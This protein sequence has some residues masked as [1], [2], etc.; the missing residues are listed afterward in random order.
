M[1]RLALGAIMVLAALS[2]PGAQT[3]GAAD[4]F[5]VWDYAGVDSG[6]P[7]VWG[8]FP[9]ALAFGVRGQARAGDIADSLGSV[10]APA[11]LAGSLDMVC[12]MPGFLYR[13]AADGTTTSHELTGAFG[14]GQSL[15]MGL[16]FRWNSG[17]GSGWG[18]QDVGL[19]V[20]PARFAS[21]SIAMPDAFDAAHDGYDGFDLGLSLRPLSAVPGRAAMLT[22]SAVAHYDTGTF[23]FSGVGSR[24][25]LND[26]LSV[27]GTYDF[28]STAFGLGVSVALSGMESSVGFLAPYAASLAD[29]TLSLAQSTRLGRAMRPASRIFGS[30]VL[31][32]DKPGTFASSPPLFSF[33]SGLAEMPLWAGQAIAA[34]ESA[35]ADPSIKAIVMIEPPLFDTE[36]RAQEFGRALDRFRKSGKAIYVYA[37]AMDRLS[38]IYTA[39]G[40][41]LVAMDPNGMLGVIDVSAF[42]LYFRELF[43]KL[44]IDV[45][46]LR[47]HDAKTAYNSFSESGMTDA[48]RATKTRIVG[49][50]AA[51]GY[52]A[53]DA[54]HRAS[55]TGDAA[56]ALAAGPYLDPTRAVAA[57]LV[58]S[59]LYRDEFDD[60]VDALTGRAPRI[61]IRS[62]ARE[63]NLAWPDPF[64]RRVAIVYLSG[65]IIEGTGVAG[66]SIGESAA[67][68][69]TSLVDDA[70]VSGVI[71]R[72][73]SGGGSAMTSDHI[74]RQV[75]RLKDAHKPVVVSMAGYAASGGYYISAN[76]DRILAEA[77]TMTGSIGVTG[78]DINATR[79]L[80]SLGVGA[81]GVSA[82]A[83]GDYG[84]PF[85][86]RRERDAAIERSAIE[87]T[88]GRFVDVVAAGR[89]MDRAAVDAL[90][91][92][93]VW[94][95]SEALANGLVDALGGLDDAKAAIADM[96]GSG[97]VV[98]FT[99]YMPGNIGTGPFGSLFQTAISSSLGVSAQPVIAAARFAAEVTGMGSGPLY[100]AP[101][102][103]YRE[104]P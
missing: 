78:L 5:S 13:Y 41:E 96:L 7:A 48:D 55:M 61:D 74:A 20:R 25:I 44:G 89:N 66:V 29:G 62:Y 83:S 14:I 21:V 76:A 12:G 69:L 102:Y 2:A 46:N 68:L 95:G 15:A 64:V 17:L 79:L 90:G 72:V 42:S 6:N 71:L 77:G 37:T 43:N 53:L 70:T 40:A 3:A 101:E 80:A 51:Q 34:I 31:V 57:G 10:Y 84:N 8:L 59:L 81:A 33:D 63:R 91:Q 47:S 85:L 36:A 45:Y 93:Q 94:L 26:W 60:R 30:S 24:F 16:R 32:L 35:A 22:V 82:S 58:D 11:A 104:R 19:I 52:A 87:Y 67:E 56:S 97:R 92:G 75:K 49:G 73:D 65:T 28:A 88:Y 38:Y 103:L 18:Q 100:L 39:S 9:D 4:P 99:D 54:A 86:P 23:T 98:V 27:S 50:L 1:Y